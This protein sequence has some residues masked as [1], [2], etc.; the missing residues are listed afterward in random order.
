MMRNAHR[1]RWLA[2]AL[3]GLALAAC[4]G[5]D[6]TAV[7]VDD[8]SGT[9]PDTSDPI[10]P[11][12]G[13]SDPPADGPAPIPDIRLERVFEGLTL[14]APLGM[15]QPPGDPGR[16]FLI[17]RAGR[18]RVLENRPGVSGSTVALDITGV[19]DTGRSEGGLL[20][21]AFHPQFQD[22]GEIYLYYTRDGG[23]SGGP[24]DTVVSRFTVSEGPPVTLGGEEAL[25]VL[26]QF[27]ANH[28]GGDIHFGPD[29][30]LYIGLGDGGGGNDPGDNGQ[31]PTTLLG[32]MLRIDV[33]SQP[34]QG[35]TYVIPS[36]NPFVTGG[37][38]PEVY[39]FG[40]RNPFRWSFDMEDGRLWLGDVGQ[41]AWEEVNIIEKG[42]NY[43]WA[44]REGA[45]PGP[46]PTCASPGPVDP[47]AEYPTGSSCAVTGGYVYR[48]TDVPELDGVYL[49][50]D[51]CSGI[52]WGL[53]EDPAGGAPLVRQLLDTNLSL[54][55]FA[56]DLNGEVYLLNLASGQIFQVAPSP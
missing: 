56:Q 53:R 52:V 34:A 26:D 31:D 20:G 5:S 27:A 17:E 50:G 54:A 23:G 40:L 2:A 6:E 35:E 43:G 4:N 30:F 55:A 22:N 45:H 49:Y 42:G 15:V 51:F 41:N 11:D 28:N 36:D 8:G 12:P 14:A 48:G 7:A 24:L 18:V 39:A 25:L 32:S 46:K 47:I 33:T 21:I 29:G 13:T 38:A 19:V 3:L 1:F 9:A 16:W 37:G 44:C 10:P